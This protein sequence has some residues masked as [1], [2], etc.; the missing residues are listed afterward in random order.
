MA[1]LGSGITADYWIALSQSLID[2]ADI[3]SFN[4]QPF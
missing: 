2:Q 3:Q 4:V 1:D